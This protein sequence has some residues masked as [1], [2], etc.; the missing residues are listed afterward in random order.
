MSHI[1][2]YL[3]KDET[4]YA[5]AQKWVADLIEGTPMR[6][7]DVGC[8]DGATG[9]LLKQTGK[10]HEVHGVEFIA[11]AAQRAESVLDSVIMGNIEE[12]ELPYQPGSFDCIVATEILEHLVDPWN[13]VQKLKLY[14]RDGGYFI[15][16]V[17][18]VRNLAVVCDLVVRGMWQYTESGILD[19][20]HL[21]FFT[22][23]SLIEMFTQA[24]LV[25]EVVG[26]IMAGRRFH[27]IN[28]ITFGLW[29][30]FLA[31]RYKCKA[32]KQPVALDKN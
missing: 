32:R 16:S 3:D 11:S 6:V 10:A 19:R 21:R 17:P 18:N 12:L 1:G 27:L 15:A 22:R 4:Y 31:R 23:S 9:V 2:L 24:D 5:A 28:Q 30:G 8:G 29:E 20:S 25:V 7:L 13:T 14:L 26:P